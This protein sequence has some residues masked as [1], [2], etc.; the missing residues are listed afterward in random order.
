MKAQYLVAITLLLYSN[1]AVAQLSKG[2]GE[3]KSV[4]NT[5]CQIYVPQHF[6]I[7]TGEAPGVI[8]KAS[9]TFIVFVKVP[10]NQPYNI[11]TGLSKS[12]F[13]EDSRMQV[14][15]YQEEDSNELV[16]REGRLYRT[17]YKLQGHDFERLTMLIEHD[18]ERYLLIGNY[19]AVFKNQVEE[20]VLQVISS[21]NLN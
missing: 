4:P 13:E 8:H 15:Y 7:K 21:I 10:D 20:E 6:E 14:E 5:S 2:V 18:R 3:T 17:K 9:G 16:K 12:F 19:A 11:D 1:Y